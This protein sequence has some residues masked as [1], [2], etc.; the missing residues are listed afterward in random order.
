LHCLHLI[1]PPWIGW[2]R[3]F[4]YSLQHILQL[5]PHFIVNGEIVHRAPQ[6]LHLAPHNFVGAWLH[7][8]PMLALVALR[9][10]LAA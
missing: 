6:R 3:C 5:W 10:N 9:S 8:S 1:E 2:L 7:H 4:A